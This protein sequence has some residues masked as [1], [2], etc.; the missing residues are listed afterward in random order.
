MLAVLPL[1]AMR[2][3]AAVFAR[4]ASPAAGVRAYGPRWLVPGLL[5]LAAAGCRS[6]LEPGPYMWGVEE[7][8]GQA[9]ERE[10]TTIRS[11]T[12]ELLSPPPP[13]EV[14][15]T[16]ADRRDELE[17]I[18][19]A[20]ATNQTGFSLGTDLTG[21]EQHA[22]AIDL[23]AS[24]V[25]AVRNNPGV[26]IAA[27]E[28][29]VNAEDII[30][31]Q[32]VFDILLFG[33]ATLEKTDQPQ[34][35]TVLTTAGFGATLL[36]TGAR[37][38]ESFRFETG[39]R[40]RFF[41]GAELTLSADLTRFRN[42]TPGI[43]LF[44]D[45]AYTG[46]LRMGLTQP[47]L[48]GFGEDVNTA[49]IRIRVNARSRAVEQLTG[50]LLEIAAETES[51]YWDLVFAWRDLEIRQWLVDVGDAVRKNLGDRR[52]FDTKPAEYSDAV[53]R[54][55]QRKAD[56]IRARRSLWAASDALKLLI[57]DPA[58]TVGSEAVLRPVDSF[59][60]APIEFD[61]RDVLVTALDRRPEIGQARL[62]IW[63][64]EIVESVADNARL[65]LLDL[66][67]RLAYFGLDDAASGAVNNTFDNDFV[68]YAIGLSFEYPLGNRGPEAT[69][70]RARLR[71]SQALLAYRVAVRE[72]VV[73]VKSALRDVRT[74]FEL[75]QATRSFRVAQ[76]ENLRTLE[77]EEPLRGMTP[78][79]LNLRFQR[80]E[81]LA[82]AR[83]GELSALTRFDQSLA[84]LYNAMGTGLAMHGI[85]VEVISDPEEAE[86]P[87]RHAED[88]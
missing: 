18:S 66:S 82:E 86:A 28:P 34:T 72:V 10:I 24:I 50:D 74:N 15:E 68:D 60:H 40:R 30:A 22:V 37:V 83:R 69:Y 2:G 88:R 48:R 64:A 19:P 70:R 79:F 38:T 23:Q 58:L 26:R 76:A 31:A 7:A 16:L 45:P 5:I 84:D 49:D 36:G 13:S 39:V 42:S 8:I 63:D 52:D 21:G 11:E 41:S 80:Q 35:V 54:V 75:I 20:T 61:L 85:H 65:P 53:A 46:A 87:P 57:N 27:V 51:A 78:E 43:A 81:T 77:A 9:I 73:A 6:P 25:T 32:A 44:P 4:A 71:R 33:S 47:L 14:E 59:V 12:P 55:E 56:V 3:Q 67:G 29:A 1:A 62:G 17:A